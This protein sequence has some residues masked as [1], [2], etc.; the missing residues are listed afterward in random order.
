M[1]SSEHY[2]RLK[3]FTSLTAVGFEAQ[4]RT[5]FDRTVCRRQ[6]AWLWQFWLLPVQNLPRLA[7]LL[8]KESAA[9][10]LEVFR[11]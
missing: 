7:S 5:R 11:I 2:Q 10:L 3:H 6:S 8:R 1:L 9:V 4:K